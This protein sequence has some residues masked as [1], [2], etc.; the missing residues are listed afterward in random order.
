MSSVGLALEDPDGVVH[1][2]LFG[3]RHGVAQA[4]R[5]NDG[6]W[7]VRCEE[8]VIRRDTKIRSTRYEDV[9]CVLCLD[10]GVS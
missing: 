3:D 2:A 1:W 10:R 8:N 5:T 4:V 7:Y 6:E 9:N